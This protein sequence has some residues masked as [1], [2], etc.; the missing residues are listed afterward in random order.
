MV[1]VVLVKCL[2]CPEFLTL[3]TGADNDA[4]DMITDTE[5]CHT[6]K[7]GHQENVPREACIVGDETAFAPSV[8]LNNETL[9]CLMESHELDS[10]CLAT[11]RMKSRLMNAECLLFIPIPKNVQS[12]SVPKLVV[13]RNVLLHGNPA[14]F[15]FLAESGNDAFG[16]GRS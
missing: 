14:R 12:N 9:D 10:E 3:P 5:V 2:A 16:D 15:W 13:A 8:Q 4:E 7:F 6:L 1:E 11:L